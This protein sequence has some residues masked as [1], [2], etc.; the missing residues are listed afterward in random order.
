MSKTNEEILK[1]LNR[2][3]DSFLIECTEDLQ[4]GSIP[5]DSFLRVLEKECYGDQRSSTAF[6]VHIIDLGCHIATELGRRLRVKNASRQM[7]DVQILR[8]VE[9]YQTEPLAVA[10]VCDKVLDTSGGLLGEIRMK[11]REK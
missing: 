4:K 7:T 1:L 6:L 10:N 5:E 8:L 9:L 11:A 3:S 2:L